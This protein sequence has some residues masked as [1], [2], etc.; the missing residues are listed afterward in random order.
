[1]L[2][3]K[4]DILELPERSVEIVDCDFDEDERE[5]YNSIEHKIDGTIDKMRQMGDVRSNYTSMLVLLL[6][7]RQGMHTPFMPPV[8]Q[9]CS[10]MC[11]L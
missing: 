6:R 9:V 1:M 7:L 4:K 3:R 10:Q 2:R 8:R 5:F 11:S